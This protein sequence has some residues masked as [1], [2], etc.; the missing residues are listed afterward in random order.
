[1]RS[2]GPTSLRLHAVVFLSLGSSACFSDNGDLSA[3]SS[4]ST[5]SSGGGTDAS[6]G[7]PT[8][9]ASSSSSS[10]TTEA[11]DEDG[12][13]V[14]DAEDNCPAAPNG[15]QL[16]FD[17]DAVGNVCDGP[18]RYA[19]ISG[20]PPAFNEFGATASV[21]AGMGLVCE[22]AVTLVAVAADVQLTLDDDGAAELF[23]S[24][25]K[26]ADT[27]AYTCTLGAVSFKSKLEGMHLTGEAPSSVGFPFTL[28]DHKAG[29]VTG[30]TDATYT[31]IVEGVINIV[32]S[33]SPIVPVGPSPLVDATFTFPKGQVTASPTGLAFKF[34]DAATIVFEQGQLVPIRLTGLTGALNLTM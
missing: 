9:G 21:D 15:N 16:D 7:A 11:P 32:E 1:M 24:S 33:N 6:T 4:F 23:L 27:P 18:L 26:F 10:S 5:G 30:T 22:Y 25:L 12:D 29:Q 8:T 20:T 31:V 17:A 3:G 2:R 13:T 28:A 19:V 14:P 34:D